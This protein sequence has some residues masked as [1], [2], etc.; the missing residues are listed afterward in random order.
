MWLN[1]NSIS[2]RAYLYCRYVKDDPKV[3]KHIHDSYFA[4]TY[5]LNIKDRPEV[6]KHITESWR[7]EILEID[8]N[9]DKGILNVDQGI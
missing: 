9:I 8:R 3:R 4:Y 6:R 5:C 1:K 2:T 7:L